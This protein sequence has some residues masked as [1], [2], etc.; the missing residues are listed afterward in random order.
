[1]RALCSGSNQPLRFEF[2]LPLPAHWLLAATLSNCPKPLSPVSCK[3][4]FRTAK[5][6]EATTTGAA[7]YA[8]CKKCLEHT[9]ELRPTAEDLIPSSSW[10]RPRS[11]LAQT[12]LWGEPSMCCCPLGGR[13]FGKGAGWLW[14]VAPLCKGGGQR[15]LC[16]RARCSVGKLIILSHPQGADPDFY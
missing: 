15:F 9:E 6:Y 14:R 7:H 11:R 8:S 13:A 5:P 10:E 1:M 16:L 4:D 2:Q 3:V 12:S